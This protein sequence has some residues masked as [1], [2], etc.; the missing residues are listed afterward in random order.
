M[1][2][3]QKALIAIA[4]C[5]LS[6]A[7]RKAEK[8]TD[9]PTE[10]VDNNDAL[11]ESGVDAKDDDGSTAYIVAEERNAAEAITL[12]E[13]AGAYADSK[14]LIE[15]VQNNDDTEVQ[16]LIEAGANV[17]AKDESGRTAL[18]YAAQN[19][20]AYIARLLID[21]GADPYMTDNDGETALSYAT[22][23]SGQLVYAINTRY[24]NGIDALMHAAQNNDA[25]E[26]RRLIEFG[27]TS[28]AG[29]N[30]HEKD[31]YGK[32]ALMYA[33]E[34]NAEDVIQ[35]L[36][37][38]QDMFDAL[39][40]AAR[41]NDVAEAQRLIETGINVNT[42]DYDDHGMTALIC[43][44]QNN[45]ADVAKVLIDAGADVNVRSDEQREKTVLMHAA[46][47]NAVDVAK[48][49]IEHG[50]DLNARD[51][52]GFSALIFAAQ[53]DAV[54]IVRLLIDAGRDVNEKSSRFGSTALMSAAANNAADI[55]KLLIEKGADV[56]AK[57][58]EDWTALMSAAANNAVDVA[59]LLIKKGADVNAKDDEGWSALMLAAR[60]NECTDI[61]QVLIES[62]ADINARNEGGKT[63][64]MI[65]E[66]RDAADVSA[67]LKAAGAKE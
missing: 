60:A 51:H 39:L 54:D 19:S 37:N 62:G 53:S 6:V 16:R 61:A 14:P 10:V 52:L 5:A 49:L 12:L 3:K 24:Y 25:A 41:N 35:L 65:A 2:I 63:A 42:K 55:A 21:A 34:N 38:M 33:T 27:I 23:I 36:K 46:E 1:N 22:D 45:A 11:I 66:E 4:L 17:N 7:C 20:E 56:N 26:V 29:I 30:A 57:D 13:Y 47:A 8:K 58:Y 40:G 28:N 31:K 59:K 9:A 18:M 43:A 67:L 64:L 15:A 44:A 50:V 48:L 32:T